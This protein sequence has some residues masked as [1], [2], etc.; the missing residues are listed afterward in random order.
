VASY[1]VKVEGLN[2]LI[3]ALRKAQS[4][5]APMVTAELRKLATA[6]A[7]EAKR[8]APGPRSGDL[9]R[10][11]K[12]S[13][14]IGRAEVRTSATHRGYIYPG[15]LEYGDL[16]LPFLGPAIEAKRGEIESGIENV[17]DRVVDSSGL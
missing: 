2:E 10:S 16:N 1:A 7:E 17:I 13:V 15:R 5:V 4:S 6:V 11:I 14:R 3:R 8:R 12:P 9:V